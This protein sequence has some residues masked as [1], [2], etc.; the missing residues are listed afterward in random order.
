MATEKRLI[1]VDDFIEDIKTEITN[2][3]MEGLKGTP[4][5][6]EELYA[7][8]DRINEQPTVDAVEVVHGRWVNKTKEVHG[9]VD[10]RFDCSNCG[11]VY[12]FACPDFNYCPNCGAKMDGVDEEAQQDCTYNK[13]GHCIGQKLMPECDAKNCDRRK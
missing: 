7:I 1:S 6:R 2:L 8:I 4:R 3:A 11:Q 5:P 12:W 10:E 13:N 9:M